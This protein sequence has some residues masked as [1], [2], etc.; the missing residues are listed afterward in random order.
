MFGVININNVIGGLAHLNAKLVYFLLFLS[1][2]T[3]LFVLCVHSFCVHYFLATPTF[4]HRFLLGYVFTIEIAVIIL[5][6]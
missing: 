4:G 2:K 6:N 5:I 3:A 1:F